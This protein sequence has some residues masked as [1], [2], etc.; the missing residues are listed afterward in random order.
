VQRAILDHGR[1]F[2]LGPRRFGKTAI[3][4][5]AAAERHGAVVIRL[6]AEAYPGVEGLARAIVTESA[7][8]LKTHVTKTGE[9][10]LLFFLGCD[11]LS[12]MTPGNKSWSGT[13]DAVKNAETDR[14][15]RR[16][17]IQ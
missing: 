16:P 2:L 13:V 5:A 17:G 15:F 3:L 4:R 9:K 14:G 8:K 7:R 1:L 10:I 12:A 6:D 11:P